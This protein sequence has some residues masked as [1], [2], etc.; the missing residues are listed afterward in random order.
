MDEERGGS[1]VEINGEISQNLEKI[2]RTEQKITTGE[3][4]AKVSFNPF[5]LLWVF[6]NY[7]HGLYHPCLTSKCYKTCS[8]FSF[9]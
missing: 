2:A 4:K 7:A 8:P 6:E 5:Y 3:L 9:G 1:P